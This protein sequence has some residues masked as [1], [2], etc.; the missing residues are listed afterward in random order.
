MTA[1]TIRDRTNDIATCSGTTC[2]PALGRARWLYEPVGHE[3][4]ANG[5]RAIER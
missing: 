4:F 3:H 5:L 2:R 1:S